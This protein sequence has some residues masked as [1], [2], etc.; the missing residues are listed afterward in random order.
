[1]HNYNEKLLGALG[2]RF[3]RYILNFRSQGDSVD[4]YSYLASIMYA[5]PYEECKEWKDDKPYPEGKDRRNR[6]KQFLLPVVEECGGL[7]SDDADAEAM[8]YKKC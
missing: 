1:M 7:F 8:P 6:V 3:S 5:L 2:E 4:L